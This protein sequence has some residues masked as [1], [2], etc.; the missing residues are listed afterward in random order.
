ME[1]LRR[2]VVLGDSFLSLEKVPNCGIYTP[3]AADPWSWCSDSKV[4]KFQFKMWKN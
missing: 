1:K 2:S 3:I 4:V